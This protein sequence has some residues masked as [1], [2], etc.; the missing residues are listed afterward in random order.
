MSI[1]IRAN[2]VSLNAQKIGNKWVWVV[3]EFLDD[4]F[5]NGN[6]IEPETMALSEEKLIKK[7]KE[8]KL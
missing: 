8:E 5:L 2:K 4:S 7:E 1:Q 3:V 6:L